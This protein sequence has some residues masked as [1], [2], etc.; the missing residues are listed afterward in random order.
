MEEGAPP[1]KGDINVS[2]TLFCTKR[3]SDWDNFHKLSCD[4]LSG[5]V[6]EDD[7]QIKDAYVAVRYDKARPRIEILVDEGNHA[8]S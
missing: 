6:Y 7:S 2:I 8:A 5:I 3:R 4:A 1:L